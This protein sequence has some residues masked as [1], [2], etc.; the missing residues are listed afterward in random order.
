MSKNLQSTCKKKNK[1]NQRR[2]KRNRQ[3][4]AELQ[5]LAVNT[6]KG[7]EL[8]AFNRDRGGAQHEM[9]DVEIEG[10]YYGCKRRKTIATWVK[11]EKQ[12]IGVVI[13]EDRGEP[14]MVVPL[15]HYCLLLSLIKNT[16]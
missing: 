5:R 1:E 6:A 3:R 9:G 16:V 8:E 14:Y 2:G 10:K 15:D 4:G 7:Y 11:P 12:E 13:R